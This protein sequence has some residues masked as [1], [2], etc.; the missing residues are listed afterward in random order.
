[1][2]ESPNLLL[3]INRLR[4]SGG[5]ETQLTTLVKGL[6]A[7]GAKV[8]LCCVD[9]STVDPSVF[10]GERVEVVQ[11]G[12]RTRYGRPFALPK[13]IRLAR[14]SDVVHC[15]MWDPSLW[16]R[17]AAI[18]AR[19]PVIVADHATDRSVQVATSGASREKWIA[20]HNRIL[21]RFT[22]A[23]V[24]CA[25]SQRQVLLEEGVDPEKIVY[26]PNGVDVEAF[27]TGNGADVT[28]ADLGIGEDAPLVVQVGVFRVE[29]NQ[30]GAL[31]A[32]ARVRES[33]PDAELLFVGDGPIKAEVE[34]RA[35]ELG[36]GDWAHFLGH[37]G[38]IGPLLRIADLQ[39][40]PSI[41]DAMPMVVLE[42]LAVGTP[43]LATDVGDVRETLGDAGAC[44]AV[45]D[46]EAM[47][48]ECVRLLADPDLRE[49]MARAGRE[50]SRDFDASLMARRYMALFGAAAAGE[51]PIAAVDATPA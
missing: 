8:T 51:P 33:I 6:T 47:A 32:M 34:R 14:R 5:A 20:A 35:E 7:L 18:L 44:V 15:T 1:M 9:D 10:D 49:R 38:D 19:R 21:D 41:S 25:T 40:L 30:A 17:I 16:G 27:A 36:A 46:T 3:I 26:I 37:R 4:P 39:I 43:V 22:Y 12:V 29:K 13:L 45:G 11:L 28:R 2:R 23:T 31:E 24:A 42:A 48:A 50:R